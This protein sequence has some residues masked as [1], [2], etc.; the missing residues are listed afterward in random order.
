MTADRQSG[1]LCYTGCDYRP[2]AHTTGV[3]FA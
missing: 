3:V 2:H 1:S